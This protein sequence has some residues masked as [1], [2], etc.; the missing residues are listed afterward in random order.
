MAKIQVLD[1]YI[2]NKISAGEVVEKPA[3]VV[4]ELVEN[5]LD[6][7][8]TSIVVDIE[9][10]GINKIVVADNGKG[11]ENQ[12]VKTAF[13]PHATSKIKTVDDLFN[14]GTLGFRGEALASISAVSEI[15]MTTKTEEA[16]L[17][18]HITIEGGD[19]VSFDEKASNTGTK[20][21]VN[22][23][24][25]NTPARK[26]FLRKPKQEE[27]DITHLMQK[28]ILAN[29][30]IKFKYI[31]DGKLIYNTMGS[32]CYDN[33]YT[34][35][36]REVANNL[37]EIN[38][39]NH[40][41]T[42]TG[43]IGKPII[44][45]PNRTYQ[46]LFVNNRIV[47]NFMIS[48]AIGN[49]FESFLMKGKFPFYVLNLTIPNDAIDV[50]VH[51]TKQEI[52]FDNTGEIYSFFL[53]AVSDALFNLNYV[54]TIE[55]EDDEAEDEIIESAV[56][57]EIDAKE[58]DRPPISTPLDFD[59]YKTNS[60]SLSPF[61][62]RSFDRKSTDLI[63]NSS[64]ILDE[65]KITTPPQSNQSP[66]I[67]KEEEEQ[68]D[69]A[70]EVQN[71]KTIGTLFA[72]YILLEAEDKLYIIDQHACHER[73]NYDR[74]VEEFENANIPTQP[75]MIPYVFTCNVNEF[76]FFVDNLETFKALGFE[77]DEFGHNTLK[78]SEIPYF[79]NDINLESLIDDIRKDLGV[80]NKT[81]LDF[82]KDSLAKKA[83]KASVKAGDIL[84]PSEIKS[85]LA[86]LSKHKVLLCPHGRP[87]VV[88]ITKSQIEKWF[89]RKL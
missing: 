33:I 70:K 80:F 76:S 58:E 72:T 81:Q 47:T 73:K 34:I 35:Y 12:D 9:N 85:L 87:I 30:D 32:G 86:D 1:K 60:T 83:C 57:Q 49:A 78:I 31:T 28:F 11:I 41:Y 2:A 62:G 3:S 21:V 36:G 29:P 22:N 48:S 68:V 64:T 4:K 17:G 53:N 54:S 71:F 42:L 82:L 20:I 38:F 14:I 61:G 51:P 6:A 65:I 7:G 18:T 5:S 25:F 19:I 63:F 8:A 88:E 26:K 77:I 69:F 27:G 13:L 37:I 67:M 50:N 10:G 15:E 84:T 56:D 44:A 79:L 52:K 16:V 55:S 59:K 74:F 24:F 45:K 75:L 89:K 39:S 40:K 66:N 46:T 43:Y 23:L